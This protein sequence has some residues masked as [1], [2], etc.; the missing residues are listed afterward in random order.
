MLRTPLSRALHC[1]TASKWP[2]RLDF[3]SPLSKLSGSGSRF[4]HLIMASPFPAPASS[5]S[6]KKIRPGVELR[7]YRLD[8]EDGKM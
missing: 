1:S 5:S 7:D 2:L 6:T 4:S 3:D 8:R